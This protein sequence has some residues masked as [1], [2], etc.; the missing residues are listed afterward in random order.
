MTDPDPIIPDH[1]PTVTPPP[2][3]PTDYPG[4]VPDTP[5]S[6]GRKA[7]ALAGGI[8]LGLALGLAV[9]AAT[10]VAHGA[11]NNGPPA[12]RNS[13]ETGGALVPGDRSK[14]RRSPL[15][16]SNSRQ[17]RRNRLTWPPAPVTAADLRARRVQVARFVNL[18]KCEAGYGD[19]AHGVRWRTP[20]GWKWQGGL[21]L[22][23]RTHASVGHPYGADLGRVPWRAQVLVADAV[24]KRYGI[25]AWSAWRCWTPTIREER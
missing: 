10:E 7:A 12:V 9:T 22:Y 11:T 1:V 19:G 17:A 14:A 15:T 4:E 24:R 20:A 16:A 13:P 5:P 8:A 6:T 25:R 18:A 2:V 21:G 23:F 3:I